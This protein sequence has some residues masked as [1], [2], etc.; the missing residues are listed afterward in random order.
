MQGGRVSQSSGNQAIIPLDLNVKTLAGRKKL[1]EILRGELAKYDRKEI[2]SF[3]SREALRAAWSLSKQSIKDESKRDKF[4][5][6][7]LRALTVA[8]TVSFISTEK[9][10]KVARA[11]D[12]AADDAII[13]ADTYY[14]SPSSVYSSTAYSGRRRLLSRLLSL[15]RLRRRRQLRR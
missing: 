14:P 7:W 3:A 5:Y 8:V 4:Y 12:N 1:R 10:R 15:C 2:V 11:A 9:S 13:I 6:Y